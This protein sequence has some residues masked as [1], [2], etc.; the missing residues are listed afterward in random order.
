MA[1]E[2]GWILIYMAFEMPFYYILY[3]LDYD[4]NILHSYRSKSNN[5]LWQVQAEMH[6]HKETNWIVGAIPLTSVELQQEIK[7]SLSII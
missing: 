7:L 2:N 6:K 3:G 4:A 5:K 1:G